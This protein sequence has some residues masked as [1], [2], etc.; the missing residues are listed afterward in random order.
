MK[1]VGCL[2]GAILVHWGQ[3]GELTLGSDKL[4][5]HDIHSLTRKTSNLNRKLNPKLE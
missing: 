5:Y 2:C 3:S 4:V 1:A